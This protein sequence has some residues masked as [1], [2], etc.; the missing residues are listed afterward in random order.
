MNRIIKAKVSG[1]RY[2]HRY[3]LECN[4][5]HKD[6]SINGT[7]YREGVG[8]F[9]SLSCR[10]SFRNSTQ[11]GENHNNWKGGEIVTSEG[12][13]RIYSPNHPNSRFGYVLKH[14][15]VIE[16]KIGRY[17]REDEIVHH[18]NHVKSDNRIENLVIL[19]NSQHSTHHYPNNMKGVVRDTVTGRFVSHKI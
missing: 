13:I 18:K 5:C 11:K 1:K 15:L 4:Y 12:Y 8:K 7:H 14:R 6:F 3:I 9:C 10:T 2:G 17:L 19:S 16:A